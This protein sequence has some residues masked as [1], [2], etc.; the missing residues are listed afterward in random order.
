MS[1]ALSQHCMR[2]FQDPQYVYLQEKYNASIML[3]PDKDE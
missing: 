2:V 1:L 3:S